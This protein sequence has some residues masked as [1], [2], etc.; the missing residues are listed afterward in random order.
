MTLDML[1]AV[2]SKTDLHYLNPIQFAN[3]CDKHGYGYECKDCDYDWGN[4]GDMIE[5]LRDRIPKALKD[6]GL[7][8]KKPID[9]FIEWL[10]I[11]G[12]I[13]GL[14]ATMVYRIDI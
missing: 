6:G 3:F 10:K 13:S 12:P 4:G 2:M 11:S 5:D 7:I 1:G 8:P 14:G 9:D